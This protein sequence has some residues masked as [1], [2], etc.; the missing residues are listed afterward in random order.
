MTFIWPVMLLAVAL[1]PLGL[2]VARR[3]DRRRSARVTALM[4]TL[5]ARPAAGPAAGPVPGTA[6]PAAGRRR[7]TLDRLA[8]ALVVA[9]ITTLA[10]AMA[11]PQATVS[12]PRLEG[13]L[14][15][16]FDVSGS[17]AAGDGSP[18]RM[19]AAKAAAKGIV[20]RQPPG[21]VIGVVAFSDAGLAVQPPTA[22]AGRI[23]GAIDRMVPTRGTSLGGGILATLDAIERAAAATPPDYYSNRTP[24]PTPA[25]APGTPGSDPATIIV[26][27]SDGENNE[28][29]DPVV[30]ARAAAERGIRIVALG[31]G[32]AAGTTLDLDGFRVQSRLDE[33]TL[34]QVSD[35]TAGAYFAA[36]DATAPTA[37]YDDLARNLVVRTEPL[38]ITALVAAAGLILLSA[39]GVLSLVRTG[40]LP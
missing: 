38:E 23:V 31:V 3:I 17:M 11:R 37:V 18:T 30:A 40:R 14:M 9:G 32:T 6:G 21:V 20:D 34:R 10:V 35:T 15:L 12:L 19:D 5:P 1:V 22:D 2:L 36:A 16:T 29:P 27:L 28:R 13:T 24:D 39:G 4:G 7:R 8:G 33:A 25:P 26:L